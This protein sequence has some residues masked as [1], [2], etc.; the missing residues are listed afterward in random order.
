MNLVGISTL[1][2][3]MER[4]CENAKALAEYLSG[5][6]E[7]TV[8]YPGLPASPYHGL[9]QKQL[10]GKGGA[11]VTVRAGSKE[12]AFRL[13]NS[14]KFASIATNI[15]DVRALVIHPAS[16]IYTHSSEQQRISAGVYDDTIRISV[17]I[18][19]KDDLIADFGQTVR[20]FREDK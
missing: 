16:T 7:L 8:N 18:E 12:K 15:G 14:L 13:I 20:S 17:G 4:C 1:G 3:R 5:F 6:E 11:I 19:D 9:V 2:L 10:G